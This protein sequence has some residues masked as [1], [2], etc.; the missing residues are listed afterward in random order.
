MFKNGVC[1]IDTA[2]IY[3]VPTCFVKV[4]KCTY[5][6]VLGICRIAHNIYNIRSRHII[7][8]KKLDGGQAH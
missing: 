2:L 5:E 6:L 7:Y 3:S 8:G 4:R 1:V